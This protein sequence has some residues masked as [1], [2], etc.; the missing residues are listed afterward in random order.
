MEK[1]NKDFIDMSVI[2]TRSWKIF[3]GRMEERS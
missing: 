1:D 3:L 2:K